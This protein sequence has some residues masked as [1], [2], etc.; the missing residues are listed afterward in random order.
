MIAVYVA[1]GPLTDLVEVDD[2]E[3]IDLTC[4]H[5]LNTEEEPLSVLLGVEITAKV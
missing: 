5:V 1:Q 2:G 3:P 4:S